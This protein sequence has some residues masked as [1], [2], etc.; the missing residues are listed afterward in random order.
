LI[1]RLVNEE[2]RMMS[3]ERTWS[4]AEGGQEEP[5]VRARSRSLNGGLDPVEMGQRSGQ[6]RREKKIL[7]EKGASENALTFRQRLGVSL[8][9]LSQG[10]LDQVVSALAHRGNANALAR[11]ADQAFGK[12]EPAEEDK[13]EDNWLAA[14]T[15]E[16]RAVVRS[17]I[18]NMEDDGSIA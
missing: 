13:P 9:R 3:D 15:R 8:S 5:S 6:A 17:W 11:L 2:E 18:D 14:L 1:D 4:I 10:E 12:P 16:Q 7:R